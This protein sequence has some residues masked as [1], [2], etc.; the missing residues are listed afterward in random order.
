[1]DDAMLEAVRARLVELPHARLRR[2]VEELKLKEAD[3][4]AIIDEPA[5]TA[6]FER[7][8]AEGAGALPAAKLLRNNLSKL[9]NEKGVGPDALGV[10]AA[11][12]A[13]IVRLLDAGTVG[14]NVV[15]KLLVACTTSDADPDR[16]AE[17]GGLVQ[18]QDDS[19]LEAWVDE[20]L[21]NPKLQK[22]VDDL[23]GG[24]QQAI[25]ALMGQVMRLSKGSANPGQVTK[26]IMAKVQQ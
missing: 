20:V 15:D 10:S 24:K 19:Q 6:Y 1:V 3:A 5:V 7:V 14:S 26:L 21:A 2:Y 13:G 23:R 18:V 4:K 25:G 8:L 16:L 9:A 12:L 22:A 17:Q 11:Q